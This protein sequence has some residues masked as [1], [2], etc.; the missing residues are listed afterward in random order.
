MKRFVFLGMSLV[1]LATM[2]QQIS[3]QP[4]SREIIARYRKAIGAEKTKNAIRGMIFEGSGEVYTYSVRKG[5]LHGTAHTFTVKDW[6]QGKDQYREDLEMKIGIV[7][8]KL[9]GVMNKDK[10]WVQVN[11]GTPTLMDKR[12]LGWARDRDFLF[13][14]VV[15]G[16]ETFAKWKLSKPKSTTVRGHDAWIIVAT[17]KGD[18]PLTLYFSEKSGFLIRMRKKAQDLDLSPGS[19]GKLWSFERDVYLDNWKEY[20]GFYYPRDE[21]VFR[22]GVLFMERQNNTIRLTPQID[23][24][25]F[26]IPKTKKKDKKKNKN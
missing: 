4:P 21:Q 23:N 8:L 26:E 22:D 17:I 25:L 13:V 11:E 20:N 6:L 18:N 10:G 5:K 12:S 14:D 15:L 24:K 3:A 1:V 16:L 7:P 2:P 9:T 19:A